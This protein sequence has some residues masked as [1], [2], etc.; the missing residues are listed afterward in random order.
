MSII[1]KILSGLTG[2]SYQDVPQQDYD[3]AKKMAMMNLGGA[4]HGAAG[5]GSWTDAY[6][7]LSGAVPQSIQMFQTQMQSADDR[8][9]AEEE[10]EYLSR[11]RP[12]QERMSQIQLEEAEEANRQKESLRAA[13][14]ERAVATMESAEDAMEQAVK[15]GKISPENAQQHLKRIG[16]Y[17]DLAKKAPDRDGLWDRAEGLVIEAMAKAGAMD[18][19]LFVQARKEEAEASALGLSVE[20]WKKLNLDSARTQLTGQKLNNQG[21]SLGNQ[22]TQMYIDAVEGGDGFPERDG[23]I[24]IGPNRW[25]R[26]P[27]EVDP[28]EIEDSMKGVAAITKDELVFNSLKSMA[29]GL[30]TTDE[31]KRLASDM[32]APTLSA[33]GIEPSGKNGIYTNEDAVKVL[34]MIA[35]PAEARRYFSSMLKSKASDAP[36]VGTPE[37]EQRINQVKEQLKQ[38][39]VTNVSREAIIRDLVQKGFLVE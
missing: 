19:W 15:A 2:S 10:R 28:Q 39:G 20:D 12:R 5:S 38:R 29:A 22:Q 16:T 13:S 9:Y 32:V 23:M 24:Q 3:V 4:L 30:N 18:E 33:M 31:G 36:I 7:I 21:R 35:N 37:A 1:D 26:K 25:V 8:N 27:K 11:Q 34:R 17:L 14:E 6:K